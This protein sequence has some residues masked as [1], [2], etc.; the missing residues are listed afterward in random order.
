MPSA[1]TDF[2]IKENAAINI[3]SDKVI[4]EDGFFVILYYGY[5]INSSIL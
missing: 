3:T 1:K 4:K 5:F 2:G